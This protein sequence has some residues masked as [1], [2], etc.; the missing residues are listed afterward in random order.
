MHFIAGAVVLNGSEELVPK[1]EHRMQQGFP[2]YP[3]SFFVSQIL[4]RLP[5]FLLAFAVPVMVVREEV[6]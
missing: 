5:D 2:F 1:T 3:P 4:T 6:R